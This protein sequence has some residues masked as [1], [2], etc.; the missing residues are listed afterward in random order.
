VPDVRDARRLALALTGREGRGARDGGLAAVALVAGLAMAPGRPAAAGT[1][2]T[3]V[4]VA[5]AH[6]VVAGGEPLAPGG[7]VVAG[8]PLRVAADGA[9]ALRSGGVRLDV[10][11]GAAIVRC[12]RVGAPRLDLV[13]GQVRVRVAGR[14][15]GRAQVATRE[16][17]AGAAAPGARFTVGRAAGLRRT[18][19]WV[20]AGRARLASRADPRRAVV[21]AVPGQQAWVARG[22]LPWLDVWPF[23]PPRALRRPRPGDRLP[24]W[25]RDGR[26]CSTGC[27]PL[28]WRAW[29]VRPFFRPHGLRAGLNELRPSGFHVGVDIQARDRA[30]VYA[31]QSGPAHLAGVGTVDERVQVGDFVYWHVRARVAEGQW[32]QALSTVLGRLVPSAVHLHL[33]EVRDG[34]YLNPL[35]PGGRVLPWRDTA[36]PVIETP[37]RRGDQ[38]LVRVFDPQST[39]ER[40]PSITPVLAPAALAWRADGGPLWFA[41]RGTQHLPPRLVPRVFAPDAHPGG[42]AC[43]AD[44]VACR[45]NWDYVLAGGL[46]PRV[47]ARARRLTVYAWDWAG[48]ASALDVPVARL[49]QGGA[50]GRVP[51]EP[52]VRPGD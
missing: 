52:E 15:P 17:V 41:Y 30:R 35:R 50:P 9:L 31:L 25:A 19:V 45:P 8:V 44:Q 18:R 51:V 47:P 40:T 33:S 26:W 22:A 13:R 48:N 3:G 16:G 23:P 43:F 39:V 32:V 10:A 14:P 37:R 20:L 5:G 42:W 27:R 24:G 12:G 29:P 1:C 49:A 7:A 11:E 6:H 28:A 2:A 38:V 46:A 4:R 34:R 21:A 36:A